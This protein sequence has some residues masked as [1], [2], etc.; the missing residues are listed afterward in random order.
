[1]VVCE[2][3]V[4][5]DKI[6]LKNDSVNHPEAFASVLVQKKDFTVFFFCFFF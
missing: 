3:E 6:N 2:Y 5:S 4:F 1:M